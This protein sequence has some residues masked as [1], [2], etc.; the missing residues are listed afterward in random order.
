MAATIA[1]LNSTNLTPLEGFGRLIRPTEIER[2]AG[3][4]MRA[5]DHDAGTGDGGASDADAG[6]GDAGKADAGTD[7][8][9]DAGKPDSGD[10]EGDD[11]T[12]LLGRAKAGD[13]DGGKDG[14]GDGEDDE[15]DQGKADAPP[16]TYE[17]KPFKVGE[18]DDATE[19]EIDTELL[20]TVTPAL[21]EA[22]ISQAALEKLAPAVVPEIQQRL[23]QRLDDDWKTTQATWA[24]EAKADPE[25][26]KDWAKTEALAAKALDMF[27]AKSEIKEVDGKQV[28]TN[29]FR[30]LL[31]QSGVGNHKEFIRIFARI[32]AAVGEDTDVIRGEGRNEKPDRLA[33]LYP[34]D[35]PANQ[36][37][38]AK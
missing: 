11:D 10:A 24:R 17:L 34:D 30:A 21:K 13:G 12:S 6:Q 20:T 4:L 31:N 23:L 8:G 5:P 27:G 15:G 29:P 16:E 18:G 25:L 35:V 36:K 7:G 37:Q 3:R 28:E 2:R 9:S 33:A 19:V 32:G 1:M 38:G 22:G 14:K 26:G